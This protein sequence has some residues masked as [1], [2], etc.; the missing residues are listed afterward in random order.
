M[1]VRPGFTLIEVVIVLVLIG[2]MVTWAMPRI[3]VVQMRVRAA[4]QQVSTTLLAAQQRAV[5]KQH[6]V[7]VLFDTTRTYML[8]H[9]DRNNDG[10][11]DVGEEQRL[12]EIAE[13]VR[14]TAVGTPGAATAAVTFA[15]GP[16]GF[17][18][19]TFHRGGFGSANGQVYIGT[20]RSETGQTMT[21][22]RRLDVERAT[23]RVTR[24][25]IAGGA[26]QRTKT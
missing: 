6:D 17:P 10:D 18:E 3:D 15:V 22:A 21:D 14:F 26:W 19:L 23:G 20:R 24:W 1:K 5:L 25:H 11:R 13:G 7:R 12:T 16:E 2:V 4:E 9:D 8:I